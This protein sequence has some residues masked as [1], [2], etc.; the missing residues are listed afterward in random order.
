MSLRSPLVY[1]IPDETARVARAAC[2]NGNLY[3][4]MQAELGMLY[5]N[6][7]CAALFSSTEQP[8]EDP[9]RL[10]LILVMQ[11]RE[12]L[13]DRQA[14]DAVRSRIDWKWALALALTDPG[15]DASVLSEFRTRLIDGAAELVLFDTLLTRLHERGLLSAGPS[16]PTR[17]TSWPRCAPSTGWS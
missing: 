10:A 7:Q 13:S 16:A 1:Q 2:P 15:F 14:A 12:G 4:A 9:A 11:V 6:P 8:A 17:R 5:T 3:M